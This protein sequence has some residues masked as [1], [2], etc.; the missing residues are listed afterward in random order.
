M[1]S[2][3]VGATYYG[4]MMGSCFRMMNWYYGMMAGSGFGAWFYGM[5]A[6]GVISGV[7]VLV[8]AIMIY[9][10]PRGTSKWGAI[11]IAS[12]LLSLLGMDGFFIGAILGVVGGILA[13]I[14]KPSLSST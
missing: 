2:F 5:A 9:T 6:I 12:S 3:A 10:R 8:G 14:W 7:V 13:I 4:G 11:V 1:I